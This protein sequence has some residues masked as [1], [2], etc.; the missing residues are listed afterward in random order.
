ML[1]CDEAKKQGLVVNNIKEL[2]LKNVNIE[3]CEGEAIV[4]D[5]VDKVIEE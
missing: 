5:N 1:G 3:G 2:V 4:A